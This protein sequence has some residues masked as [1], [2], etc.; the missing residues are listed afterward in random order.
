LGDQK[1]VGPTYNADN[2]KQ[3]VDPGRGEVGRE[4]YTIEQK[5]AERI[6]K[7]GE[8]LKYTSAPISPKAAKTLGKEL[9]AIAKSTGIE[10]YE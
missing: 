9:I 2:K 7:I 10:T 1:Q 3:S 4:A 6:R 5:K 8:V